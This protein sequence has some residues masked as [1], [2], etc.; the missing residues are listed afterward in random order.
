MRVTPYWEVAPVGAKREVSKTLAEMV[1]E[2]DAD[3]GRSRK[4]EARRRTVIQ[5]KMVLEAR[6]AIRR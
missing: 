2:D 1:H 6:E 3:P 4:R 5:P